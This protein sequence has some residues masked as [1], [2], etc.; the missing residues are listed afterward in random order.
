M[1]PALLIAAI[2][3]VAVLYSSV[4]HGGASGYLAVMALAAYPK[5]L[6]STTA[7]LLNVGVASIAFYSYASAG[8]FKWSTVRLFLLGS[9]PLAFLGGMLAISNGIY[10]LLLGV[11]LVAA[12]LRM[13]LVF[14]SD[15]SDPRSP[16]A[17]TS[18]LLGAVIGLVSGIVGVGGG[19]FLSPILILCRWASVKETAAASACFILVNSV[20]GLAGRAANWPAN[21]ERMLPFMAAA[22]AGGLV[23]SY[24]G[25]RKFNGMIL[26]RVLAGVM[27]IAAWK[28]FTKV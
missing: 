8:H 19:I 6:M 23:G 7:L 2:V 11:A 22:L 26:C 16:H 13:A 10:Y 9:T 14:R 17:V 12:A 24:L 28:M 5:D 18:W 15:G 3:A 27:L 21:L 25:S 20:A 4:G 1:D